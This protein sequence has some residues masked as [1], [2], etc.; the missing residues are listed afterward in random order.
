MT[1]EMQMYLKTSLKFTDKSLR[2]I[3][4]HELSVIKAQISSLIPAFL[5]EMVTV[6]INE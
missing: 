5:Q 3:F 6:D 2:L 1:F 4:F